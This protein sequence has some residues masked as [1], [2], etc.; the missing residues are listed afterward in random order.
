MRRFSRAVLVSQLQAVLPFVF[1]AALALYA[2]WPWRPLPARAAPG[3]TIIV[4]NDDESCN[5]LDLLLVTEL[6]V[7]APVATPGGSI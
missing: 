5:V 1:L 3:R 7:E 2:I 4:Y 6:S